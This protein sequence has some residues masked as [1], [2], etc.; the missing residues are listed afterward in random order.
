MSLMSRILV[1]YITNSRTADKS[2]SENRGVLAEFIVMLSLQN[3]PNIRRI[4]GYE[5]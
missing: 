1:F 3:W 5:L 2:I 4:Y